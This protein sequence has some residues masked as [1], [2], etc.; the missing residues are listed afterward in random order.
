[1]GPENPA[2]V[3]VIAWTVRFA[4]L[5]LD[6]VKL[7]SLLLPTDTVPKSMA[8]LPATGPCEP[9]SVTEA[10]ATPLPCT[11]MLM[12]FTAMNAEYVATDVGAKS[13]RNSAKLPGAMMYGSEGTEAETS[14]NPSPAN[15]SV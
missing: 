4:A 8:V 14:R 2:P 6:S 13:T 9:G 5:G 11:V 7:C 12:M 1:M 10:P 3:T 15:E